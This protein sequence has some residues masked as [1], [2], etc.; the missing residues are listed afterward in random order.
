MNKSIILASKIFCVICFF[1]SCNEIKDTSIRIIEIEKNISNFKSF[2]LSDLDC[3]LEYVVLETAPDA[4]LM[5]IRF[6]DISD[7]HIIVADRDNCLLFSRSGRFISKIGSKGRGPGENRAFTQIKIHN[8]RI[9]LPDGLSDEL[10]IFNITGE[11]ISSLKSPGHFNPGDSYNWMVLTDSS[12][13][14]QIPNKTG[15]ERYRIALI[16]ND[17]DILQSFA[18]THFFNDDY[19]R[20][21]LANFYKSNDA[22]FYKEGLNDT[23]WKVKEDYLKPVY[24]INLGKYRYT[25]DYK[26][27]SLSLWVEKFWETIGVKVIF[28]SK[29]LICFRVD[30]RN[31]YPLSFKRS[32]VGPSG[33]L[34]GPYPILGLYDKQND[35]FFLVEPSNVN[36]QIEPTGIENDIDGGINF[37]PKYAVNDT[38]LV[39]WFQAYQ[40]KMYVASELFKNSNLKFPEKKKKLEQLAAS[41]NENDNPVLMLVK[42]KE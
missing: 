14:V 39:G 6:V 25:F 42:L 3:K 37:M 8:D 4:M 27:Y 35:D 24:A 13:F 12:Y 5:D 38:L 31:Q 16:N 15:T 26:G 1:I 17:G 21:N 41:L 36:D 11:F 19:R 18:N 29:N 9:F 7:S 33:E 22:I 28:E 34:E 20:T 30:F 2:K 23:I 10:N 32:I 40:L